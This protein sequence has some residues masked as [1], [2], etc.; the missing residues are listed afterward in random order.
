MQHQID[1]FEYSS[2]N[3]K[4]TTPNSKFSELDL[5]FKELTI[6]KIKN[7]LN[8]NKFFDSAFNLNMRYLNNVINGLEFE[9]ALFK[10]E[11]EL[12]KKFKNQKTRLVGFD[13]P[14]YHPYYKLGLSFVRSSYEELKKHML[15]LA[16]SL[17]KFTMFS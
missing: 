3:K 7:F 4:T 8:R 17:A 13:Y 12:D 9:N 14:T 2:Y 1:I 16:E 5:G 11:K 15:N 10:L 6:Y